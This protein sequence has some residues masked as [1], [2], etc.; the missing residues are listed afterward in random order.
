MDYLLPFIKYNNLTNKVEEVIIGSIN[1]TKD[2]FMSALEAKETINDEE[3]DITEIEVAGRIYFI[4][5]SLPV[6]IRLKNSDYPLI[7]GDKN[8]FE[9]LDS[10]VTFN[11]ITNIN[12]V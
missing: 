1:I 3:V 8:L 10:R 7:I 11:T 9:K 12:K 6:F 5:I 2:N 4:A